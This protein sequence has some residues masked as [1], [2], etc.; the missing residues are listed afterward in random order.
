MKTKLTAASVS[1]FWAS[2]S[3]GP[4][5]GVTGNSTSQ[6]SPLALHHKWRSRQRRPPDLQP[7]APPQQ[8]PAPPVEAQGQAQPEV[9]QPVAAGQP[10]AGGQWVYT[11]DYGW[12][13]MPYGNQYVYEALQRRLSLFLCVLPQLRMD[14]AG[15]ALDLGLG[16]LSLLWRSRSQRLWLVSRPYRAGYGWGGY[17]GGYG[18]GFRG[19]Y[20]AE[21]VWGAGYRG[22]GGYHAGFRGGGAAGYRSG[23]GGGYRGAAGSGYHSYSSGSAAAAA[24]DSA[25]AAVD[26]T[27][28]AV[29]STAAV[30][31]STA[32]VTAW[33]T[34]LTK[35]PS[36]CSVEWQPGAC[37]R[38][39][40]LQKA[41]PLLSCTRVKC[42]GK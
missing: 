27:A 12:I 31:D 41:C 28:A 5:L 20:R 39:S 8:P 30:V 26:S 9:Q 22:V 29:D 6:V 32:A 7:P 25:A 38:I 1:C 2:A 16:R 19:G 15:S 37:V 33:R 40:P 34:S 18:G 13:W 10:A 36:A 17:R 21:L 23:F 11:N 24:A 14:V 42:N 3:L 35:L 4:E